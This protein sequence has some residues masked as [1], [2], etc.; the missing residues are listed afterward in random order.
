MKELVPWLSLYSW[1]LL[2]CSSVL[3]SRC[4]ATEEA[5]W[6]YAFS[7]SRFSSVPLNRWFHTLYVI[8]KK[9]TSNG[10]CSPASVSAI[11]DKN[12]EEVS[13]ALS[14][15]NKHRGSFLVPGGWQPHLTC[16]TSLQRFQFLKWVLL[17]FPGRVLLSLIIWNRMLKKTS[18]LQPMGK[19]SMRKCALH[20]TSVMHILLIST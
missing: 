13:S 5:L 19:F 1:P 7:L 11:L 14:R 16:Q 17:L 20:F 9:K 10:N 3:T 8:F 4:T 6:V 15:L 18:P 2:T 12:L